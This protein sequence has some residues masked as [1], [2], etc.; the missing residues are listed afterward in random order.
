[1][2]RFGLADGIQLETRVTSAHYDEASRRWLVETDRGRVTARVCVMA[3]G[4][5]SSANLPDFPGRDRF[6]G[7]T[8]HTGRWPHEGVDFGGKR[9]AVIGTGSSAIQSVPHIAAQAAR[10]TVFQRTPNYS[11]PAHNGPIDPE[12]ERAVKADYARFRAE[13]AKLT[14][15]AFPPNE[16][17]ALE[18]DEAERRRVYEERWRA[19]GLAFIT[20][21]GDLLADEDANATAAEFVREKIDEIVR[22]PATAAKLSPKTVIG[23]K[24]LCVDT[25][26]FDTYNRENVSLVDVNEAPIEEITPTGL[27][28]GGVFH[29]LDCI[30][31]ATGFDAMTGAVSRI[32]I[33]GRGDATLREK[34]SAGPRTY[35]GLGTVGFPNLFLVTGPGSPSVLSNMVPSIEQNV[36]WIADCIAYL[37][38]HGLEAIEARREAQDA[39][40]EHVNEVAGETLYPRCNSWYL[41][42]NVPGKPRVFM[43]YIGF[44]DY[45]AKCDEVAGRGYEGF[46]LS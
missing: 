46:E 40:V 12:T 21:F 29:P 4:C 15:G 2:G 22:D 23:C 25:D 30:V 45:C 34:W 28:A 26:Y 33:R 6:A 27:R 11:I 24:R 32:D 10:L 8:Y 13:K 42:A 17:P 3:T 14:F 20:A 18:V 39:W 38:E 41:G 35:L 43:P 44:P 36:N 1:V 37:R 9:V 7:E 16:T 31:F 5:L 19:G